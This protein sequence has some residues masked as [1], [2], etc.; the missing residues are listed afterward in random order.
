[1]DRQ[2]ARWPR[3]VLMFTLLGLYFTYRFLLEYTK[4]YQALSPDVPVT[5]GQ[6]LSLPPL[7]F[8]AWFVWSR[9]NAEPEGELP[10]PPPPEK[11]AAEAAR[12]RAEASASST[13]KKAK[14]GGGKKRKR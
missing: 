10:P 11:D 7:L 14:R 9:R 8:S 3:G 1:M 12:E 6:L 2:R 13:V 4:E 5:M